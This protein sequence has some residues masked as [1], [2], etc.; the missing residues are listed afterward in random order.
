MNRIVAIA[1]L[2]ALLCS[3]LVFAQTQGAGQ[4]MK[5]AGSQAKGAAKDTGKA[6]KKTAVK[7]KNKTKQGANKA[8][9]KTE[10]GSEKVQN[11][12]STP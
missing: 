8:A 2:S 5:N 11:K 7:A 9:K 1:I 12:T 10:Q 6:T 4:D 3:P